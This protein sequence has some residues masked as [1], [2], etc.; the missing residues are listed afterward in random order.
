VRAI[1]GMSIAIPGIIV[2]ILVILGIVYLV[3][4]A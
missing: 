1:L 4:R 2:L 3:R